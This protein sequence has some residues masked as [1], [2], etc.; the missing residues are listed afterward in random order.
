MNVSG[1]SAAGIYASSQQVQGMDPSKHGRRHDTSSITD[2]DAQS[3][4]VATAPSVTGKIGSKL[5]I[6]V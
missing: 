5:N 3:S 6:T 2:V 4:S 1:V